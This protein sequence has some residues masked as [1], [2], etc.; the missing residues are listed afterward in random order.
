[1]LRQG[2]NEYE[3]APE[4][5]FDLSTTNKPKKNC[6]KMVGKTNDYISSIAV[7][8]LVV[9]A[10]FLVFLFYDFFLGDFIHFL[11]S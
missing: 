1:M 10:Y 5:S 7:Q 9:S 11:H 3:A 2:F 6:E 4:R 8:M